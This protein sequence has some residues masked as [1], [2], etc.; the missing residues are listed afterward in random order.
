MMKKMYNVLLGLAAIVAMSFFVSCEGPAGPAGEDGVD[1]TNGETGVATCLECHNTDNTI[2][3]IDAQFVQSGHRLGASVSYA[4]GRG[5]CASC[6]SSEGFIEYATFGEVSAATINNP[7]AW[8]CKTCHQIHT[9][10]EVE[11]YA[12]RMSDPIEWNIS[13]GTADLGGSANLCGNCH[14]S[15][16]AEP[17]T[18]APGTEFTITSTHYGPHH[19]P[20]A[21]VF[22]G[23]GFAEI[24]GS[25]AYPAPGEGKHKNASCTMCHMGEYGDNMGGHSFTANLASCQT[26][27]STADFNYG[28]VQSAV[29]ADLI[30]LRDKLIELGVVAGDDVDGY[31]PVTGTYPMVQAQAYYNWVGL[32]E[33]R[34][35]GVHNPKYVEA[36]IAN[37]LEALNAK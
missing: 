5:A 26:C 30:V 13:D 6:H 9:T 31:H 2:L 25:V 10:F 29:E 35:N 12:L 22:Y 4:G 24:A 33:D 21:N 17:N 11:D 18:A 19:G 34:S 8:E 32:Y 15:R 37:T 23:M 14:Q 27:H 36:L 3:A 20:Q 1:G 28:G 16:T 7:S